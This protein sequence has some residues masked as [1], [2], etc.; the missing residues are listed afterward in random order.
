MDAEKNRRRSVDAYVT[1]VLNDDRLPAR[2]H[3]LLD[4]IYSRFAKD[5]KE[6]M[7]LCLSDF[8][9]QLF[10]Q[11]ERAPRPAEQQDFFAT[12]HRLLQDRA[13]FE[14][15][16]IAQLGV[17]FNDINKV[18]L[19]AA[20][21]LSAAP[22]QSMELLDRIEQELSLAVDQLRVR[23]E[24]RYSTV[25]YALGY[26]FAVLACTPPLE[27]LLL[28]IG[29]H[30][31]TRALCEAATV[32]QLP[33]A[34]HLMLLQSFD[35]RVMQVI[36]PLY[37]AIN[38]NL[39]ED[40][41]LPQLRSLAM[42]RSVNTRERTA[43][44]HDPADPTNE[45]TTAAPAHSSDT[46][47]PG[48]TLAQGGKPAQPGS[49]PAQSGIAAQP[50]AAGDSI[51]VL[52]SLRGLLAQ[53]RESRGES[54]REAPIGRA[55]SAD[56]LQLA[57]GALQQHLAHVTDQAG[58]ELRSAQRLRGELLS[59]LNINKPAD[60]Q[61]TQLSHEQGDTVDLVAML[62][63]NLG[64]QLHNGGDF[65]QAVL[66]NMQLPVLRMAVA[67]KD[68]FEKREHPT[69]RLLD[70]VAAA[71][72]DWLDGSDD[73]AS[74]PLAAKLDQLVKRANQEPPS[75]GL[76]TSL[77]ADIEHHLA[78]LTR[79][80]QAAE[81]RHVEAA[82]GRERLD[83]ARE[84]AREFMAERFAQSSPRGLLRALLDRAWSDVLALTLLR[85]GEQSP[86]F[87]AQ[88]VITDQLLGRLPV[89]DRHQLQV[90][91]EAGL[92]QIGMHTEEAVQVAQRLLGTESP[93]SGS[94]LPSE[95]ELALRL[96]QHQRLGAQS[97]SEP[98]IAKLKAKLKAQLKAKPQA[99]LEAKPE[100][101][102]NGWHFAPAATGVSRLVT[103]PGSQ[104]EASADAPVKV[105]VSRERTL[106]KHLQGLPFGTWLEFIDP[107]NGQ[108]TLRKL[109]WHS[110]MSGRCLLV[111]RRGQRGE[112]MNM[113]QLAH[114][115][116]IG[117]VREVPAQREG[118]LDR[119]W[120]SL[121]GSLRQTAV[122]KAPA[123]PESVQP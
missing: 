60:A 11:F 93:E 71:A 122:A 53:Q 3:R 57:L 106:E 13:T 40:G 28:P 23:G 30:A 48:K 97:A 115:V 14:Q 62:F 119:A 74:R 75:A 79:K 77:L 70:T 52:D 111:T 101:Q 76:Y 104:P 44:Q 103:K 110:P 92:Q 66:G 117:R 54:L 47:Q 88:L 59:Q 39:Q 36:G 41:I 45:P 78:L 26:R 102:E 82:Q 83:Q 68:F 32:L 61:Q 58:R 43:G 9:E 69:R 6:P 8:D 87:I 24:M 31:L 38:V 20:M 21:P 55:A 114:E 33:L 112:E 49:T 67:D 96:E 85:H 19:N 2:A 80:A 123:L 86:A 89:T 35:Q 108:I 27:G 81:R 94:E 7:R 118:L 84:R 64:K 37:D 16:F 29:P 1:V 91:V 72:N 105:D 120:R 113:K 51:E 65:G 12:R 73:E 25:L 22:W 56:E 34:H 121:T 63:E 17:A 15:R 10:K 100:S 42:P 5:L 107:A 90:D 109:A 18:A 95:T 46:A 99:E 4:A 50:S 116:A 98:L